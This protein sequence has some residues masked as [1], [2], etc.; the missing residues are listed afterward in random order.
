MIITFK[1]AHESLSR[2]LKVQRKQTKSLARQ[3]K[4][5]KQKISEEAV[6]V[7]GKL[8]KALSEVLGKEVLEDPFLKLFWEQQSLNFKR[9]ATGHRFVFFV[10][11]SFWIPIY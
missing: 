7:P 10:F 8:H 11:V 5:L 1:V 3:V 9:K 4:A 2:A 6:P